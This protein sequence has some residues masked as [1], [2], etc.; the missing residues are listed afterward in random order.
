MR[1]IICIC[2]GAAFTEKLALFDATNKEVSNDIQLVK[3]YFMYKCD[4]CGAEWHQ[5]EI[6]IMAIGNIDPD[7]NEPV[8]KRNIVL[9]RV[10]LD[11]IRKT[12]TGSYKIEKEE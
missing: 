6:E 7:T 2:G 5:D 3:N 12:G 8:N 9:D 1:K 4:Q 10:L 11:E